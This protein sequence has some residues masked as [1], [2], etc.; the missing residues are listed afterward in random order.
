MGENLMGL[1]PSERNP[2]LKASFVGKKQEVLVQTS[3]QGGWKEMIL[4]E[5]AVE[6][7]GYPQFCI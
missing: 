7:L 4:E 3:A 5:V 1:A 2:C 6:L